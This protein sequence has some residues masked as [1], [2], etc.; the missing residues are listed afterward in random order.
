MAECNKCG[1]TAKVDTNWECGGCRVKGF[2]REWD[3]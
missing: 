2:K 3:E 1:R